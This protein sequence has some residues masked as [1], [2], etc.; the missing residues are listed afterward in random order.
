M[1]VAEKESPALAPVH[2]SADEIKKQVEALTSDP[3]AF[4]SFVY[5]PLNEAITEIERRRQDKSLQI[6]SGIGAPFDRDDDKIRAVLFRNVT[7]PNHETRRFIDIV[8]VL[9]KLKPVFLEYTT[10]KFTN[11]NECKFS[12]AKLPFYKGKNKNDEP[13]FEYKKILDINKSNCQP[14]NTIKTDWGQGLVDF[15]HNLFLECFPEFGCNVFDFSSWV[16]KN[17]NSAKEYYKIFLSL[18]LKQGILFENFLLKDAERTF[19]KEVVL[20][21]IIEIMAKTGLK[22]MIV[23]LDPVET[24][25][26]YF[27]QAHPIES[28]QYVETQAEGGIKKVKWYNFK[29]SALWKK[30][31][32]IF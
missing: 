13:I 12:L 15:H 24:E 7:T 3:A 16:K 29:Q 2:L 25:T 1:T 30:I 10:D 22:P 26:E 8:S 31:Q 23:I 6:D 28:R 9:D 17:G 19:T 21:A 5:T 20:P 11:R 14:I 32:N 4:Y 18:F 27:W